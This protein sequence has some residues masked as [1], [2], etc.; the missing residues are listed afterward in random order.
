MNWLQWYHMGSSSL[1]SLLSDIWAKSSCGVYRNSQEEPEDK[2]RGCWC[3][4]LHMR[5]YGQICLSLYFV[6]S[7][8]TTGCVEHVP[9]PR[10]S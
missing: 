7:S 3:I 10:C 5:V 4:F 9:A 2:G 8:M 6:S 1:P